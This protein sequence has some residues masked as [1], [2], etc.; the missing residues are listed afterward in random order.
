ML[1]L[2]QFGYPRLSPEVIEAASFLLLFIAVAAPFT[3]SFSIPDDDD[4][5][6]IRLQQQTGALMV[7]VL[8]PE[9]LA[10]GD[11]QFSVLVQDA[12][13]G[14]PLP[15][16]RVQF[17]TAS[18]GATP[19]TWIKAGHEDSAN[20]LLQ[21]AEMNLAEGNETIYIAVENGAQSVR[22]TLPVEAIAQ[23]TGIAD[24]WPRLLFPLIG[25]LLLMVYGWRHRVR[26]RR[27]APQP[28]SPAS[29]S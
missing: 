2:R 12:A 7:T 14:Q 3:W 22:L 15:D 29:P 26:A 6:T 10:A 5:Q 27:P 18:A 24:Y 23:T 20:P 16:A 11:S 17:S 28:L 25:L 4:N 9:D 21:S 13:T 8:A 1:T 19:A